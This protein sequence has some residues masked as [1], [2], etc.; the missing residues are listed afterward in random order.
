M[1][2]KRKGSGPVAEGNNHVAYCA[3]GKLGANIIVGPI[4]WNWDT[5][6]GCHTAVYKFQE[7]CDMVSFFSE[8]YSFKHQENVEMYA[9]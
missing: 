6:V 7:G 2:G 5:F 1:P 8:L 3:I 4:S 9:P